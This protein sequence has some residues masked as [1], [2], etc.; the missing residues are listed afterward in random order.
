[1]SKFKAG[2]AVTWKS[3][4]GG[5]SKVKTG[6]ITE[7]IPI[8][9][10]PTTFEPRGKSGPQSAESYVVS[11]GTKKYWPN[12]GGLKLVQ[13]DRPKWTH[14]VARS[15]RTSLLNR[16]AMASCRLDSETQCGI[17]PIVPSA[18]P[19]TISKVGEPVPMVAVLKVPGVKEV[20]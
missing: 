20:K 14:V 16:E 1:M 18:M 5:Y 19:V 7:V 2:D 8:K 13:Q 4:A 11:V 15:I 9:T 12:V 6:T 17:D 3:Q 10:M